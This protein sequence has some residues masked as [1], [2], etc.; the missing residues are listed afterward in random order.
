MR[1]FYPLVLLI[2]LAACTPHAEPVSK[3]AATPG[4]PEAYKHPS[5]RMGFSD[6]PQRMPIMREKYYG[7]EGGCTVGRQ[8]KGWC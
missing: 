6:M 5:K 4:Q 2:A 7:P 3:S 1:A 8:T